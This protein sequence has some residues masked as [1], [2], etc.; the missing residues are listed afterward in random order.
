MSKKRDFDSAWSSALERGIDLLGDLLDKRPGRCT[1]KVEI[2][3]GLCRLLDLRLR[4]PEAPALIGI[5]G[6]ANS[7]KSTLFNSIAGAEVS[8]VTPIPHQT[9]GTIIAASPRQSEF[10][11]DESFLRPTIETLRWAENDA[12]GLSGSPAEA[13]AVPVLDDDSGSF[14]LIDLP[15]V[16]T[17][18][19]LQEQHIALRM[20]PWID[21]V[22]LLVTE[23]SFAQANHEMIERTLSALHPPRARGELFVVL[24]RRHS[25]TTGPEFQ[26]RLD[27]LRG[28]WSDAA[29]SF[30]PHLESNARFGHQ[31][32]GPL[33]EEA[34]PRVSRLLKQALVNLAS[35]LSVEIAS[36]ARERKHGREELRRAVAFK[37][38]DASR[39][40]KS[41]F[42]D[43]FLRR[44]DV[45]SPWRT[46][47]ARL[48]GLLGSEQPPN[49]MVELLDSAPIKR[50]AHGVLARIRRDLQRGAQR[51]ADD[52][53]T[54]APPA[55]DLKALDEALDDL[56]ERINSDARKDVDALLTQL[57][58]QRKIKDPLWSL[59]TVVASTGL[60]VDLLLPSVGTLGTL[61]FSSALSALG[62]GGLLT[63]DLMRKLRTGKLRDTF[64][65]RM[66][67]LLGSQADSMLDSEPLNSLDLDAPAV[68]LQRWIDEIPEVR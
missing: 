4:R 20:L 28:F 48:K 9:L 3:L 37:V 12:S 25:R 63:S 65:R 26:A 64:E 5:L 1:E 8:K 33:V 29:V 22:I 34:N 11:K 24:N 59:V 16:G 60:L 45:F 13:V 32:F 44:M 7:G 31:D 50:H 49:E 40:R 21:R 68:G 27:S 2:L 54:A 66:R 30:L 38:S 17:V 19:S 56:V 14:M 58:E 62:L 41:F 53:E 35:E 52:R 47:L 55:G 18:E 36:I 15:D 10:I 51:L 67:E 61:T 57:Q 43:E 6:S 23:E 42:S 39:F 46:S